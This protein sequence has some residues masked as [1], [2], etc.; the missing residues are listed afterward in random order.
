MRS[1]PFDSPTMQLALGLVLL[2]AF[3]FAASVVM[4]KASRLRPMWSIALACLFALLFAGVFAA[5]VVVA[6][7]I[8]NG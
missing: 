3:G 5:V 8:I 7:R 2:A 6:M 1:L 4:T